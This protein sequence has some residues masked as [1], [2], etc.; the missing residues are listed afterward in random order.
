MLKK[1]LLLLP[2]VG[3]IL[4]GCTPNP[5]SDPSHDPDPSGEVDPPS[6]DEGGSTDSH[7]LSALNPMNEPYINKQFYLNHIGDIYNTWKSYQGDGI[8][9]A[10]IDSEFSFNH[11]D[12]TF[13]DGTSKIHNE[14]A[15]FVDGN[16][17]TINY[18]KQASD[19]HGTFC[20]GI[21][22]AGINSKG[23][24]GI[25]PLAKLM[26]LETDR[27]PQSVIAAMRHAY[28]KG[29]KVVSISIGSYNGYS[30][31]LINDGSDLK[32]CFNQ[33]VSD[34]RA[35]G[36]VI[37][38]AAG[39]G[40]EDPYHNAN[41]KTYP[42]GTPG[43]IGVGGLQANESTTMWEG[44]SYNPTSDYSDSV[45]DKFID[46][47][48][49]SHGMFGC[50]TY[51]PYYDG[52]KPDEWKGT[53]FAAPIVAGMAAL[54]FEK[55]PTA[56]VAEFETA[57]QNSSHK[58]GNTADL[59]GKAGWGRVDV[60]KLLA[61]TYTSTIT[62]K[63]RNTGDLYLY[64][65]NTV[66]GVEKNSWSQGYIGS[67]SS[68]KNYSMSIDVSQYDAVIFHDLD[69]NQMVQVHPSSFLY[70]NTYNLDAGINYGT[71]YVGAYL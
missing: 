71:N 14:S 61:T 39:N 16:K 69:G 4:S 12:F 10:V 30:G 1:I 20:A 8:T 45:K 43:V 18:T 9:I 40:G 32:T 13:E 66:T 2:L 3:L 37:I 60:G 41:E 62:M 64:A 48:A 23:V 15:K 65:W 68:A 58:I 28:Q 55:Y 31:D 21:A 25:A 57:L 17:T 38:S 51:S 63:V 36:C 27:K 54:Y 70:G 33:V 42:G 35:A 49:P 46:V 11:Q 53:S 50:T 19:P 22:A 44:S 24:I 6:G 47:V 29:A 26:L 52:C 67:S 59:K 5:S 7:K 34:A 56:T